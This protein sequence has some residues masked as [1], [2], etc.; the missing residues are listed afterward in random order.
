MISVKLA[1]VAEMKKLPCRAWEFPLM[2][3]KLCLF[4]RLH[5][6][7][8]PWVSDSEQEELETI[9]SSLAA[10][11]HP[12]LALLATSHLSDSE[13]DDPLYPHVVLATV[14]RVQ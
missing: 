5:I 10:F 8:C 4:A 9:W 1:A 14:G 13:S 11:Q 12:S 7:T 6:I 2:R 3:Y